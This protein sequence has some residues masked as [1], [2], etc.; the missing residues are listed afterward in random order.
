LGVTSR[1]R[2]EPRTHWAQKTAEPRTR[3]NVASWPARHPFWLRTVPLHGLLFAGAGAVFLLVCAQSQP[4][5]DRSTL[6]SGSVPSGQ[7]PDS[8]LSVLLALILIVVTAR[9]IGSGLNLLG[10]PPVIGEI[11]GGILLGPSFF[12]RVSPDL[13]AAVFPASSA[14]ILN[15]IAQ[16][17]VILY[18]F[19][20]GLEL[21]PR[22]L[23]QSGR[24]MFAIVHAGIAA[25]FALGSLVSLALYAAVGIAGTPFP[26]FALFVGAAVS[27][28][29]FPVLARI[30]TDQGI[31]RSPLG[32]LTLGCAA[33]GDV[34]AWCL[35]ALAVAADQAHPSS[36]LSTLLLTVGYVAVMLAIVR[37]LLSR[38]VADLERR[39]HLTDGGLSIMAVAALV[40]A[41]TTEVIGI[42]AIFGAFL[43]GAVVPRGR[44]SEEVT[45]QTEG[46]VRVVLLPVFFAYT[47]LRTQLG[48]LTTGEEWALCGAICAVATAGK[49]GGSLLGARVAGLG[50]R[51]AAAVG[52]LMNTRGLVELIVLNIGLDLHILSPTLF[53]MF[54]IMALA[55][56]TTSPAFFRLVARADVWRSGEQRTLV[57]LAG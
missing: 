26:S 4:M 22:L 32:Q 37:P 56:T 10:Q 39:G 19:L 5:F 14:P 30:L 35:L 50:W 1:A 41:L 13:S 54:V 34:A 29:A 36:A 17:G 46:I 20:V 15:M 45:T 51:D 40:S 11:L 52:A 7:R 27:V 24:A 57:P 21:D 3:T 43:L 23:T 25:P 53:A 33:L 47:G 44:V 42:H 31:S 49:W 38:T 9:I 16:L 8:V 2:S 28:T 48:L 18:M 6:S 12:G 55:T